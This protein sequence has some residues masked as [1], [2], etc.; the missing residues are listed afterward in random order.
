[1]DLTFIVHSNNRIYSKL[2]DKHDDSSFHIANSH[3][4]QVMYHLAFSM[5]FT[6]HSL[7]DM[8]DATYIMRS[9]DIVINFQ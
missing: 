9:L 4:F 6:F 8:Q 7:S 5:V 3:S 1:M 2:Y